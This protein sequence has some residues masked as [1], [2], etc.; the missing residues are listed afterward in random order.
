MYL[1]ESPDKIKSFLAEDLNK[2]KENVYNKALVQNTLCK[3]QIKKVFEN[4]V[5]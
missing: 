5:I 4:F 3:V 1:D 2:L